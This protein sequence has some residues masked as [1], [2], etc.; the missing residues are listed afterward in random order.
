[1]YAGSGPDELTISYDRDNRT[2]CAFFNSTSDPKYPITYR[3]SITALSD[4]IW[5]SEKMLTPQCF[6]VPTKFNCDV[7]CRP[8]NLTLYLTDSFEE[9]IQRKQLEYSKLLINNML[10][11]DPLKSM[12]LP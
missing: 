6:A 7:L 4:H 9:E 5:T 3:V 8:F 1:M 12:Q 10:E 11:I 2:I